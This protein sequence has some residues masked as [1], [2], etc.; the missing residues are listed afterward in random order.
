FG[1]A[2]MA[3]LLSDLGNNGG[4]LENYQR[5]LALREQ[6]AAADPHDMNAQATVSRAQVSV[7]QILRQLGRRTEA[8]AQF[9]AALDGATRR[10]AA[11]PGN[12]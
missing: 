4:A 3:H 11:D 1:Y 2:S 6:V 10:F 5:A 9:H 7:G 8:Q 12:G